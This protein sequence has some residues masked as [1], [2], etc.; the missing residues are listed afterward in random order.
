MGKIYSK[1][2]KKSIILLRIVER[3]ISLLKIFQ[4]GFLK[5]VFKSNSIKKILIKKDLCSNEYS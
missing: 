1:K 4:I 2:R 5:S 3:K